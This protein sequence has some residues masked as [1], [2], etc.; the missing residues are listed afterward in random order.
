MQNIDIESML[1]NL[2]VTASKLLDERQQRIIAGCIANACGHGGIKLV[3]SLSGLNYR[4]VKSGAEESRGSLPDMSRIRKE[5]AGR[6]GITETQV[7]IA[8]A[9]EEIISNNTYGDPEKVISWTSLSLRDISDTLTEKYGITASKNAVARVL[10]DLGYSRQTN[11]KQMQAG[12][13][14]PNRDEQFVFINEKASKFING[15]LPVISVDT[16]KKELIGNFKNPGTEYRPQKNP[17]KV[18]DHDFPLGG[19]KVSPYGVYVVNNNTAYVNLGIGHDTGMFA[20][21]SIR[22]WWGCVG[23]PTFGNVKKVYI[24]CDGGG[25]NGSRNRLWKYGL[26]LLAEELGIEFHVSHF[27]PGTSKWNKVEHRLFCYISRNWQGKPLVDVE[28]TIRLIRSTT[29]EKGLSVK[30][31]L[32]KNEY[33]TGIKISDEELGKIDIE[34]IE[35]FGTWNYIIHGFKKCI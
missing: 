21:E 1:K 5:G 4:T 34:K 14:H 20:V 35:P 2:F 33:E 10:D 16:K 26:A 17:R 9:I 31:E 24:N 7:G 18:L 6:P 32:D 27:P 11:Q 25:S 19:G 28:T 29:T 15:D 23:R 12:K 22:R 13:E 8:S 3:C 30:C